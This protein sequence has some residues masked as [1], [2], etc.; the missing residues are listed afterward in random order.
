MALEIQYVGQS[1]TALVTAATHE[2]TRRAE[3]GITA[4]AGRRL[5]E[6]ARELTPEET[7]ATRDQWIDRGPEEWHDGNGFAVSVTN[8]SMVAQFLES[9]VG[10]HEIKPK[11]SGGHES[12][13]DPLTGRRAFAR[14]VHHPGI[15]AHHMTAGAC[16]DLEANLP[17]VTRPA[18]EQW[19]REVEGAIAD[20][21]LMMR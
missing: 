13:I 18:L 6:V 7:H 20:A 21:A 14:T 11:V 19:A 15:E 5:Y 9:G 2:I 16:V 3:R 4:S 1:I 8:S 10:P 12:W 17:E